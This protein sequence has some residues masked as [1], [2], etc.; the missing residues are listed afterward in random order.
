MDAS[1]TSSSCGRSQL[2][3]IAKCSAKKCSMCSSSNSRSPPA[4]G[5]DS[6]AARMS[7][8]ALVTASIGPKTATLATG[9]PTSGSCIDASRK[10]EK[11]TLAHRFRTCCT[12][13]TRSCLALHVMSP[14]SPP[15]SRTKRKDMASA[16]SCA[17]GSSGGVAAAGESACS[18]DGASAGESAFTA[19][20][21]SAFAACGSACSAAGVS[22]LA[23]RRSACSGTREAV[24][25]AEESA[26]SATG[27][28]WS[29]AAGGSTCS[30]A[31]AASA[32]AS[33][34]G[35]GSSCSPIWI[36]GLC[37]RQRWSVI[38]ERATIRSK[39]AT[40]T[41][42]RYTSQDGTENSL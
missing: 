28:S 2:S 8:H 33:D 25:A 39:S 10:T 23:A 18:A 5:A 26:G 24:S 7:S 16:G 35:C 6:S 9:S 13:W 22:T 19:T 38:Q 42:I 29:S 30:A 1:T 27:S 15:W 20:G 36:R 32:A 12:V 17:S 3:R 21:G 4:A 31:G 37:R 34:A 11:R 41:R 40:S 14:L